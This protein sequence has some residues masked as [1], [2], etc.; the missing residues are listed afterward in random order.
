LHTCSCNTPLHFYVIKLALQFGVF[1]L[2]DAVC[3]LSLQY[4]LQRCY[5]STNSGFYFDSRRTCRQEAESKEL[6]L[7]QRLLETNLSAN[8][9]CDRLDNWPADRNSFW[10][11][12]G[13][14]AF[15]CWQYPTDPTEAFVLRGVNSVTPIKP[16]L[17]VSI[18][19]PLPHRRPQNPPNL[20]YDRF[21]L[22]YVTTYSR[23]VRTIHAKHWSSIQSHLLKTMRLLTKR[24]EDWEKLGYYCVYLTREPYYKSE[25]YPL[26]L[27]HFIATIS[28]IHVYSWS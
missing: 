11:W 14:E 13:L 18:T 17:C 23:N 15:P 12:G 20:S 21:V 1:Y 7:P 10:H 3:K 9:I 6:V 8:E 22:A 5:E 2:G 27:K 24:N 28:K 16:N 19:Y 25:R 26:T 4:T